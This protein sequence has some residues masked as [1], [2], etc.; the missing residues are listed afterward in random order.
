MK[1]YREGKLESV[2]CPGARNAGDGVPPG[3]AGASVLEPD[4]LLAQ[5]LEKLC[6]DGL[7]PHANEPGVSDGRR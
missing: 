5:V 2:R 4:S 6:R 1:Q 3:E 7:R